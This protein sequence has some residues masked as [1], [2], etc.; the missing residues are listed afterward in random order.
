VL[1]EVDRV[2]KRF[3]GLTAV[4]QVSFAVAEGQV[5][6]LIGPNGAGKTTLF[7]VIAG[8]QRPSSG[9][10]RF[11]D[12]EISGL[13]PFRI[14]REG[15]C[16]TFQIVKPF[17]NLTVLENVVVGA[18]T[19]VRER[20]T[21]YEDALK[22]VEAT[23]LARWADSLAQALPIGLRKRVEVA[24]ALATRPRMILLDE[25]MNGLNPTELREMM[26]LI[27]KLNSGGLTV[28]LIEH[29]MAAVMDLCQRIVVV[30]HGEKI[31]D[32]S[33]EAVTRDPGV[34]EAYLGEDYLIR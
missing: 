17:R 18:F 26:D 22:I 24:R 14:C 34:V 16:R 30:H 32:G 27:R 11:A 33:P 31:A 21:A 28:L 29:V 4:S 10:I 7:N 19:R 25:V 13:R 3:G 20:R 1:L 6:G 9:S 2:S 8:V 15:L 5:V 23:G 12:R